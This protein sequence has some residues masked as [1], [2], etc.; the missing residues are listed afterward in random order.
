MKKT[1]FDG[2][3]ETYLFYLNKWVFSIKQHSAPVHKYY[4]QLQTIFQEIDHRTPN[5]MHCDADVTERQTELDRLRVHL[6]LSGLDPQFDQV[7]GEIMQK[8]PKLD[9][10][11]T[12]AY[13]RRK[14]QQRLTMTST[15]D[16]AVLATGRPRGPPSF[17][18]GASHTQVTSTL[19]EHKC[20]HCSGSKH[21]RAGCYELIGYPD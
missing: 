21:T 5:R 17:S 16:N 20:T 1:Y 6:F 8:D 7:R 12:F 11:Q 3:D 14:A 18:S 13:V 2:G 15:P 19:P 4:S 9:L 10:D